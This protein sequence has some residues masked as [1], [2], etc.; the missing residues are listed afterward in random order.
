MKIK[1]INKNLDKRLQIIHIIIKFLKILI[2][3]K[4][5]NKM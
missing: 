1:N 5:I 3:I 2:I 4:K